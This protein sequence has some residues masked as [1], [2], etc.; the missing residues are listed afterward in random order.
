MRNQYTRS[1]W[2]DAVKKDPGLLGVSP[3]DA[4]KWL[5]LTEQEIGELMVNGSLNVSDICD[6]GEVVETIIPER[7]IQRYAI[8]RQAQRNK[9]LG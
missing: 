6:H 3:L 5:A 7:D 2:N 1:Q 9:G 8:S 4:A